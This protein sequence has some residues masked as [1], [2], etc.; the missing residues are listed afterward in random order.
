M[1]FPIFVDY[2]EDI[3]Q[4]FINASKDELHEAATKLKDS[5]PAPMNTMFEK[6]PREEALQKRAERS[7]MV[8]RDVPPTTPGIVS[9]QVQYNYFLMAITMV[10]HKIK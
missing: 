1:L 3:Y 9:N 8:T 10:T 4:T 2:V 6:Q 7:K 5:I